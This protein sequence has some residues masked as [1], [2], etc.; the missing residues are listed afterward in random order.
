MDARLR[1]RY[2]RQILFEPIGQ[3]G[4]ERL[5]RASAAVVG[6]GALGSALAGLLV[7]AGIG[8][9]R[10]IDRD[11]VEPSNLQ[12]QTLFEEAD[13][14]ELLPKAV[15][16]ERRLRTINS[17]VEV[18]GV[19]GDL[20]PDNAEELLRDS[21]VLL[22]GTDNFETRLLIN[23]F[24]VKNSVPWIYAAVVSSHGLT[25]PIHP[26]ESACLACLIEDGEGDE[27]GATRQANEPT[28]DTVGVL[29]PAAGAIASM[30][31]ASAIK[32]LVGKSEAREARLIA[33]DIWS[34]RFQSL[35]VPRREDCRACGERRFSYLEGEAQPRLTMCGRDSVQIHERRRRLDLTALGQNLG[36]AGSQVRQNDFLLRLEVPPYELTVF[37]DGRAIIKG[38]RDA[39]VARS[40][41][42]RYVGA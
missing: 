25:M 14:Q 12:R 19:V 7:R 23:D 36:A 33:L 9:L 18:Q 5:R 40:L 41:Y 11:F 10:I 17:D 8:R 22:D 2:S 15:A 42:A 13:A 27:D 21:A 3:E 31:A 6:C 38:T 34:A 30:E 37:A 29:G 16:A 28:C 24:A 26:G 32:M 20:T 39:S 4:Q 1:E 35:R